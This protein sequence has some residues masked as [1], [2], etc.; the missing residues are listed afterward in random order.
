MLLDEEGSILRA[1]G[2]TGDEDQP[3]P[4]LG[5]RMGERGKK[6]EWTGFDSGLDRLETEEGGKSSVVISHAKLG[7]PGSLPCWRAHL[8]CHLSKNGKNVG[9]LMFTMANV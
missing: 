7:L 3:S 5:K 6:G 2:C 8:T 1:M 4:S 9:E